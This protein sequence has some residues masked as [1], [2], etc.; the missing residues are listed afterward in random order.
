MTTYINVQCKC[1]KCR[2]KFTAW[3]PKAATDN[4]ACPICF[5]PEPW[6]PT[7]FTIGNPAR[8]KAIKVAE[9]VA[10]QQGFTDMRDNLREG[11]VGAK[12]TPLQNTIADAS[13]LMTKEANGVNLTAAQKEKVNN[14][15][16][17]GSGRPPIRLAN[18]QQLLAT[19]K[20]S[21]QAT[22]RADNPL[23]ILQ[24]G[25]KANPLPPGTR[26]KFA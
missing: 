19:A 15:W 12:L 22:S 4:P 7:A 23:N 21:P 3:W 2:R 16:G 5:P 9:Q 17:G 10:A 18:T 14:F 1:G 20:A 25:I 8:N 6:A 26:I 11:D 13:A 24:A